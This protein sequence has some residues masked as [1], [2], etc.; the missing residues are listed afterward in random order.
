MKAACEAV[1]HAAVVGP[2]YL[3]AGL[4]EAAARTCEAASEVADRLSGESRRPGAGFG[5]LK[6]A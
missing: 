3:L 4:L 2:I 5:E 1:V 6:A